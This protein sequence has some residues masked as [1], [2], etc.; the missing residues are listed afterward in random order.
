MTHA[1]SALLCSDTSGRGV[2]AVVRQ[3]LPRP[4]QMNHKFVVAAFINN[5]LM[6]QKYKELQ[7]LHM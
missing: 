5:A 2:V 3:S 4:P 1:Q 6:F 7:L